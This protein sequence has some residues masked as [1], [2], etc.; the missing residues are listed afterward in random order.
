MGQLHSA[1]KRPKAPCSAFRV[2]VPY[3]TGWRTNL[4]QKQ[5][6]PAPCLA[7]PPRGW[8]VS[9]AEQGP[10]KVTGCGWA[11]RPL[12]GGPTSHVAAGQQIAYYI[13]TL[14][15]K[16]RVGFHPTTRG[17]LSKGLEQGYDKSR[18]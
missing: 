5:V 1:H 18:D 16:T 10:Q 17:W 14:K 4:G 11:M 9:L 13:Q 7:G 2:A 15:T 3:R 12:E 6:L 8:H